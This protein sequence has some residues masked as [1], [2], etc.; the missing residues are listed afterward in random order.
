[1]F[2]FLPSVNPLVFYD[3]CRPLIGYATIFVNDSK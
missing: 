2:V 1:M 3:E